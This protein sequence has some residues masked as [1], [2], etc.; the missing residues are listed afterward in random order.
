MSANSFFAPT[1]LKKIARGEGEAVAP[2]LVA[3]DMQALK[4][5]KP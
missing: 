2:G 4:G 5:R 3:N 1:G